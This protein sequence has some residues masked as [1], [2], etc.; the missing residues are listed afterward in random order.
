MVDSDGQ[1][2]IQDVDASNLEW[3]SGLL[4]IACKRPKT[5]V[6]SLSFED[7]YMKQ[8]TTEFADDLDKIRNASDFDEKSLPILIEA[9][10]QGTSMYSEEEKRKVMKDQST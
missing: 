3:G 10:K 8:V 9:L 4:T 6:E 7:F 5:P 2:L 1:T